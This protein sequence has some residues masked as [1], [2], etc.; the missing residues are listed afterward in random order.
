M[1]KNYGVIT[2]ISKCLI[3][4]FLKGLE[5]PILM[6]SSELQ[7][8]LLKQPIKTQKKLKVKS[9]VFIKFLTLLGK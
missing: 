4:L 7:T 5:L 1:N 2:F 3:Y 6:T 8:C 9:C